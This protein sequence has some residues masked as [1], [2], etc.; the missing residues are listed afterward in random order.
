MIYMISLFGHIIHVCVSRL[1]LSSVCQ[2]DSGF[3]G[4]IMSL[5]VAFVGSCGE[6]L[7]EGFFFVSYD[8]ETKHRMRQKGEE[9]G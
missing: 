9:S 3:C 2:E 4:S 6:L 8:A 7:T 5:S 1:L